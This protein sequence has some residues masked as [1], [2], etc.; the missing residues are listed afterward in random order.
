MIK[1]MIRGKVTLEYPWLPSSRSKKPLTFLFSIVQTAEMSLLS[2]GIFPLTLSLKTVN[3][4]PIMYLIHFIR[5]AF[6]VRNGM[7]M[8]V[9]IV[10]LLPPKYACSG[11]SLCR[12]CALQR[13]V[14][15]PDMVRG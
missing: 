5:G 1:S 8:P 3:P 2:S 15:S 14:S 13:A 4:L 11:I 10:P 9:S 12:Q 7:V 6:S